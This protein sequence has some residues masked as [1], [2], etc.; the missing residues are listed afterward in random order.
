MDLDVM[1]KDGGGVVESGHGPA[2]LRAQV[3]PQAPLVERASQFDHVVRGH[4]IADVV[5]S[6]P[7]SG[8]GLFDA[9]GREAEGLH[10]LDRT[11]AAVAEGGVVNE[12][13]RLTGGDH[14]LHRNAFD[15]EEWP[16]AEL[17][18][19][20]IHCRLDVVDDVGVVVRLAQLRS[21]QILRHGPSCR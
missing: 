4:D 18:D 19:Q 13:R 9:L 7:G 2:E 15:D 14:V 6:R 17:G 11:V 3:L 16:G 10:Q 5:D 12:L 20:A 1:A 8:E 21:E